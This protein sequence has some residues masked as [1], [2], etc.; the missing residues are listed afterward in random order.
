MATTRTRQRSRSPNVRQKPRGTFHPRVQKVGPEHFGIVSVDCAKAR[1]QWMLCDFYGNLL[2][3]PTKVEHHR[4]AL[5]A[6]IAQV[7]QAMA[8]HELHDRVVAIE[9]TGRYHR[10]VQRAFAA[11][12]FDTRL[13]HPFA[14]EPFRQASDPGNTTDD[15]DRVAIHRAAVNGLALIE[16][17]LDESWR[18]LQL[19]IRHR[20]DLVFKTSL[21]CC[22]IREHLEAAYP[23]YAAC[24]DDIWESNISILLIRYWDSP[25]AFRQAG[26]AGLHPFRR[27]QQVRF[28]Q[29]TLPKI[30]AWAAPA[31]ASAVAAARHRQIALSLAD[32]RQ[33][34]TQEIQALERE[35]AS[36]LV[37]TPYCLV[38]SFP[39]IKVVSAADFA[40]AMGPIS[41][42]AHSRAITGRAGLRPS[43]SQ[44]DEVDHANGPLVRCAN[45]KLRAAI[46]GIADNLI[47]CNKH[48]GTRA[49]HWEAAGKDPRRRRVK[50]G[51]RFC[52][53]AFQMV[54]GQQVF[55][56]PSIQGRSYI[57]DK[58][59]AF[60]REHGT[61]MDQTMQ[62]LFAAIEQLPQSA[63]AD[64]SQPL[65]DEWHKIDN[66][67]RRGP[68]L[69]GD[70]LPIVLARW[71][72]PVVQSKP[73]GAKDPRAPHRVDEPKTP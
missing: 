27:Q 59:N 25:E 36:R 70:I 20:R 40:G 18:T 54:A 43:R 66:G 42:D 30:V 34:K 12:P 22:Q 58:L 50:I 11:V 48:F 4:P 28:Q 52:R 46:L 51:L 64:E 33:R 63:H 1:S 53:I 71:G 13:V 68:Q 31:A 3:P 56:H 62:D 41:H 39:G 65:V 21:L 72:V 37:R 49:A 15:T 61:P 67:R 45:R 55:R 19:L 24:F 26:I 16:P 17:V 47:V 23:G 35:I 8:R 32:D 9:R 2:I 57:L 38:R 29:R 73:S 60:H 44:R 7:Q 6:M 5:E 10:P 69:L 14:T